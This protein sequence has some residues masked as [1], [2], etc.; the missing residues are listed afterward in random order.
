M[1]RP[2]VDSE[3]ELLEFRCFAVVESGLAHT[4]A[5]N[6]IAPLE[7]PCPGGRP[8]ASR[9]KPHV[10]PSCALARQCA[11]RGRDSWPAK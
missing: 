9:F 7:S 4:V 5:E 2:H 3:A 1:K 11:A 8:N 10:D 6:R